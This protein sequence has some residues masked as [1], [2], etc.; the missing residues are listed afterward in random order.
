MRF[1]TSLSIGLGAILIAW[2]GA[3]G[4]GQ[5]APPP[6]PVVDSAAIRDSIA[7]EEA[8]RRAVQDSLER[9]R[10]EAERIAAQRRADSLAQVEAETRRV[11]DMLQTRVHFDY[12]RS[13]IRSGDA[14]ILDQKLAILQANPNLRIRITGHCDERGSDEYNL[15]LG[16]RRAL[17]AKQYL[18][19]RGIAADRIETASMG[20]E[21][22]VAMGSN[23]EAWAQNRRDEF[24]ITAGGDMLRGPSGM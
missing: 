10:R 16:N 5:P 3:C 22:P 24:A 14:T 18:V 1:T 19:S 9:A 2:A 15:A 4:G 17:S 8:R 23:E 21:Q 11:R 6:E 7:R 20:E 12:D 13:N